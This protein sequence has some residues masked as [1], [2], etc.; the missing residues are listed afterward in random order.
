MLREPS[1][2]LSLHAYLIFTPPQTL[3]FAPSDPGRSDRPLVLSKRD[4]STVTLSVI[5][6]QQVLKSSG[7]TPC[8]WTTSPKTPTAIIWPV[9]Q[10]SRQSTTSDKVCELTIPYCCQRD[11]RFPNIHRALHRPQLQNWGCCNWVT[12]ICTLTNWRFDLKVHFGSAAHRQLL[13]CRRKEMEPSRTQRVPE[14]S[15]SGSPVAAGSRPCLHSHTS[16]Q[17]L[18]RG[19][20][21][22]AFRASHGT[23]RHG[24]GAGQPRLSEHPAGVEGAGRVRGAAPGALRVPGTPLHPG[25]PRPRRCPPAPPQHL[26]AAAPGSSSSSPPAKSP[27]GCRLL[28]RGRRRSQRCRRARPPP[29]ARAHPLPA[30]LAGA[31]LGL[32]V[33][34]G[35]LPLQ[36][37]LVLAHPASR[38]GIRRLLLLLPPPR[39]RRSPVTPRG[40]GAPTGAWLGQRWAF[41]TSPDRPVPPHTLPSLEGR[42]DLREAKQF[43]ARTELT[44]E[45]K[46]TAWEREIERWI[47]D[48]LHSVCNN[49]LLSVGST[50]ASTWILVLQV[51]L[52]PTGRRV[53]SRATYSLGFLTSVLLLLPSF[54]SLMKGNN[55][56]AV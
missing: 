48:T 20:P 33:V 51:V 3:L 53:P 56:S 22:R 34:W 10:S 5:Y 42:G 9:N 25:P 27:R 11:S 21:R 46:Q 13:T 40:R 4:S 28:R 6:I 39:G 44:I 7:L 18:T 38:T 49:L 16:P 30:R 23:A 1:G 55:R 17:L 54:L 19:S 12:K 32:G 8:F 43:T 15:G 29:A 47:A 31:L 24:S 37:P 36:L 52:H 41:I 35:S 50:T 14:E 26:P 45:I 2:E